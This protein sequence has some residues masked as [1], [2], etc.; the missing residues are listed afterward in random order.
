MLEQELYGNKLPLYNRLLQAYD[1]A[2]TGTC[3]TGLGLGTFLRGLEN[4]ATYDTSTKE[5]VLETPSLSA[6]KW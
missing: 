6:Y 5:F 3:Q 2:I 4:K 1:L